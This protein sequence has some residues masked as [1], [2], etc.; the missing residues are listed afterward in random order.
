ML[1]DKFTRIFNLI[2]YD[3][4]VQFKNEE[5]SDY[6]EYADDLDVLAVY[7]KLIEL[8]LEDKAE[9]YLNNNFVR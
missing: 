8:G 6:Y 1:A 5:E 9:E 3:Y 4:T 2:G 7:E